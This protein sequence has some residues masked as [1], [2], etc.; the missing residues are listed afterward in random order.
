LNTL[1]IDD[2]VEEAAGE[3]CASSGLMARYPSNV[4]PGGRF[5]SMPLILY[6]LFPLG[7]IWGPSVGGGLALLAGLD[8]GHNSFE[9]VVG[10]Q[11]QIID[12]LNEI[13][14]TPLRWL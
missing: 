6:L 10:G 1:T 2:G 11:S 4:N 13:E 3:E 9:S 12:G 5:T 14:K 7:M 8:E